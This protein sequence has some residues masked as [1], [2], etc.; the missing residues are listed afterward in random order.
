MNSVE[1]IWVSLKAK[2]D[3]F[4]DLQLKNIPIVSKHD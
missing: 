2:T 3:M 1:Q 4:V